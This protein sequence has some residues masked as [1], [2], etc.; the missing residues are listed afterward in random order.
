MTKDELVEL[1]K[2]YK[3]N[4]AKLK[5]RQLEK[6]KYEK[7]ICPYKIPKINITSSFRRKL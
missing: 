5:L 1:L 7:K 4:I 2:N 6:K 3:E